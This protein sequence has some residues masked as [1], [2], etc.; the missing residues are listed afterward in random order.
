MQSLKRFTGLE[1]N[2]LL[3]VAGRPFW[4]DESYDRLVRDGKEFE[5]IAWYIEMNPVV[6]D[7]AAAP[8]EFPWSSARPIANRPQVDNLPHG[9]QAEPSVLSL[10][11]VARP[12]GDSAKTASPAKSLRNQ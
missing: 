6:A 8:E 7:L 2:R 10:P 3:G 12:P 5:R 1:G 11:E 4:Q 9:S